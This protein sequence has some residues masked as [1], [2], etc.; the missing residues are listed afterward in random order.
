MPDYECTGCGAIITVKREAELPEKCPQCG[1]A[2]SKFTRLGAERPAARAPSGLGGTGVFAEDE[3]QALVTEAK[4]LSTEEVKG[5]LNKLDKMERGLK[6]EKEEITAKEQEVQE[7]RRELTE[8]EK[9]LKAETNTL[10]ELEDTVKKMSVGS[11]KLEER[12]AKGLE[13]LRAGVN[14]MPSSSV[15]LL[16]KKLSPEDQ[17]RLSTWLEEAGK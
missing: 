2:S 14:A 17:E 11:R 1:L 9:K 13:Q 12:M 6:K 16:L 10:K 15:F 4:A 5:L 8:L 3:A 7:K